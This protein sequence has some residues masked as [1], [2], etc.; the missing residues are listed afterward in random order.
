MP[1]R[2]SLSIPPTYTTFFS[3]QIEAGEKTKHNVEISE[4]SEI[5][6]PRKKGVVW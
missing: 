4:I 6:F 1:P 5:F 2:C 3:T